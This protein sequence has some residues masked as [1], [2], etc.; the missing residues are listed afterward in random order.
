MGWGGSGYLLCHLV[1]PRTGAVA[2]VGAAGVPDPQTQQ[3]LK[4]GDA[5]FFWGGVRNGGAVLGLTQK[6]P[7]RETPPPR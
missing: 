2:E 1:D 5:Y 4:G 6:P 3:A 7:P